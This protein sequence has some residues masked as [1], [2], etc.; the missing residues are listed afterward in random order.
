MV[1]TTGCGCKE[2]YRFP[3]T[4]YPYSS[5]I[6]SFL[7]HP[8]FLFICKMF[9]VLVPVLFG[10]YILCIKYFFTQYKHTYLQLRPSH[11]SHMKAAHTVL[12]MKKHTQTYASYPAID[13]SCMSVV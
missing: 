9:F 8:Y 2:V 7:Q 13:I 12:Y 1:V 4:T 11:R 6:C 3:H 5:C 10:I